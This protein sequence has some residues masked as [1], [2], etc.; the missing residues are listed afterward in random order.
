MTAPTFDGAA[1]V[2]EGAGP[3]PATQMCGRGAPPACADGCP[4]LGAGSAA[5]PGTLHRRLCMEQALRRALAAPD[6][7]FHLDFQPKVGGDGRPTGLEALVR[8][9]DPL[10]QAVSPA[11]FVPVA[12]ET[13]LIPALG[14]WVL[15]AACRQAGRWRAAGTG[16]LPV[17]VNVSPLQFRDPGFLTAVR[18]A[19][20]A[21]GI[22]PGT[23]EVEL[24][25][26]VL[27]DDEATV[28]TLRHLR[29]L[30]VSVA[31]DDF[32]T[33]YA[34]LAYLKRLPLRRLKVDRSFVADLGCDP[35]SEAIAAAVIDLGHG[36]GLEVTA[37]GVESVSQQEWLVAR[38]CDELQGFGI[39]RPM[40]AGDVGRW[41]SGR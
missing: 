40:P 32:G 22:G 9:T 36:L 33:G 3:C 25:E 19:L 34:S 26:G 7:F 37:E 21:G 13:G 28:A 12:E 8:W 4:V 24:T 41:L 27:V 1:T 31:V 29:E 6:D 35:G 10:L 20:A 23:L 30:G 14:G 2:S 11:E 39:A 5:V 15:R 17:A 18:Q 16:S 38:G